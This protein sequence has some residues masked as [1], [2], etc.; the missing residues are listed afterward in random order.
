MICE[1]I[2]R[3]YDM[4]YENND[5]ELLYTYKKF[6][7]FM[8]CTNIPID[9]DQ[10]HDMNWYISKSSGTIQL[11]P[12]LPLNI[13]YQLS[14]YSGTIGKLWDEHH[15]K[16]AEFILKFSPENVLE[17]GGLHGTLAKKCKSFVDIDWTIIDPNASSILSEYNINAI[18]GFF[19]ENFVPDKNYKMIVHSHLLEHVY[20]I[21]KFLKNIQNI[22]KQSSGK[23]IFSIPNME[24]MLKRNYTNCLNFEH[25]Y[26]LSE[27]LTEY[28]LNKYNF[29][30]IE[31]EY[32]KDDHSIFY[33]VES[34]KEIVIP[35]NINF[36]EK[37]KQLFLTYIN[38]NL[39]EIKKINNYIS[40]HNGNIYLFG[41]HVFSQYL[42]S[43]GLN[44]KNIKCILDNDINKQKH[45]LYG[46]DLIV[47]S[48]KIL[49]DDMN[50]LVILK[51]GVYNNEIKND[52]LNNINKNTVI[53]N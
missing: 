38:D 5:L 11:N 2:N 35:K 6:P 8:G 20:D 40:N 45:R 53:I 44:T 22:L 46:T 13:V 31:K 12:L 28:Y 50:P 30:V 32:F 23:M 34:N 49:K 4:V 25:T 47:E 19:D 24:V 3:N 16:F 26:Y 7:V 36:Y 33:Y 18:K 10:F 52:I 17:I 37:N 9:N 29:K 43:Y 41:G 14:H 1:L 42:I 48:P 27:D 15:S 21:N 39:E 51:A